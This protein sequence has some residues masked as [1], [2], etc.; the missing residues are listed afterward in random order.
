MFRFHVLEKRAV[1]FLVSFLDSRHSSELLGK[2]VEALLV[3]LFSHTGVHIRPFV[4]FAFGGVQE[5]FRGVAELSQRFEPK[6]RVFFFV[7][8]GFEE[9]R[10]DL[11]VPRFLRHRSEIGILV[12][13]LGFA[14]ESFHKVFFGLGARIFA[15]CGSFFYLHEFLGG[16]FANGTSEIRGQRSF[17]YITAYR[18]FP[19]FHS[20]Y[21]LFVFVIFFFVEFDIFEQ[22]FHRFFGYSRIILYL[23]EEALRVQA[24]RYH[25]PRFPRKIFR[26]QPRGLLYRDGENVVK[27]RGCKFRTGFARHKRAQSFDHFRLFALLRG[28]YFGHHAY[29]SRRTGVGASAAPHAFF[30][31]DYTVLGVGGTRGTYV[32]TQTILGAKSQVSY[33]IFVRHYLALLSCFSNFQAGTLHTGHSAG[34]APP[35]YTKPHTEQTYTPVFSSIL[36]PSLA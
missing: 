18:A 32:Q 12:A 31:V 35:T 9:Q 27:L 22:I 6:L 4:A 13:S 20:F 11:F 3:R 36:S 34:A 15:L 28:I 7:I 33:R 25:V 29:R 30:H 14:R 24:L 2:L 8:G 16:L 1:S 10:R 5:I 17:V 23:F 21:L 19:F 26:H